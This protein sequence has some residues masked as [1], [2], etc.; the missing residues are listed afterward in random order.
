MWNPDIDWLSPWT[1]VESQEAV[2]LERELLREVGGR[3]ALFGKKVIALA[4]MTSTD[5]VLFGL[6]ESGEC[7]EVHLT[8]T[9]NPPEPEPTFPFTRLFRSLVVWASTAM[10]DEHREFLGG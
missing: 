1:P 10:V 6:L 7:A 2:A 5:D 4:R 8:W 3:H 9:A